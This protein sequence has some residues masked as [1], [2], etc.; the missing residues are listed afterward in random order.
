MKPAT[1]SPCSADEVRLA[2]ECVHKIAGDLSMLAER[3][4]VVLSIA[5]E[6]HGRRPVAARRVHVSFKFGIEHAQAV[7]HGCVLVPLP[8][9]LAL[10]GCLMMLGDDEVALQRVRPAPDAALRD[11]LVDVDALMARSIELALAS[12]GLSRMRTGPESC[13]G[14]RADARP[15]LDHAEGDELVVATGLVQ[16]HVWPPFE[17]TVVL[18]ALSPAAAAAS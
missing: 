17:L 14:V 18:P 4:L 7:R 15:A 5:V 12:V 10:A 11:A 8:D 2:E 13:Q 9:A 3:S 1:G 16:L 6:K